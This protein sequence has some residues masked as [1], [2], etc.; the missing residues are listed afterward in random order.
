MSS[1]NAGR[2]ILPDPRGLRAPAAVP[3]LVIEQHPPRTFNIEPHEY[4][5]EMVETTG[6]RGQFGA[7]GD[8]VHDSEALAI[9]D[10][11]QAMLE[12]EGLP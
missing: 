6:N 7:S 5:E 4:D 8:S 1:A 12:D 9:E 2:K 10:Q 3:A 11:L